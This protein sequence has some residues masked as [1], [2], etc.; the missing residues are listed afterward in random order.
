VWF[1]STYQE[2]VAGSILGCEISSVLDRNL[3]G[4]EL[5]LVLWHLHVGLLS[6]QKKKHIAPTKG[7]IKNNESRM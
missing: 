3:P 7:E 6:Q 5:P 4:G 2:E 1:H